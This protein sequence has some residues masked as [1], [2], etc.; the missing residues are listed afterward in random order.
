MLV[1]P[2]IDLRDGKVVRL[3]QGSFENETVYSA[4]P[5]DVMIKWQKEGAK[6]VHVV[7]LDGARE[8]T[9]RNLG[10]LKNILSVAKIPVQF[11]GGLRTYE[12][13]DEVLSAGVSRAVVGTKAFDLGFIGRLAKDFGE[14]VAIG[15]DVREGIIQTHGWQ[16]S[17][18]QCSPDDLCRSLET[19][20]VRTLIF[21]DIARDG[22]M[23]GPNV[24]ALKH[25]LESTKM[26]VILSGG[27]ASLSDL[28]ALSR[29][30]A[31]N[32]VGVIIGKALYEGK[33][34]FQEVVAQLSSPR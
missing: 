7:D 32:F 6:M 1:I 18:K 8:G 19:I 27:I 9:R 3:T 33:I 23:S 4:S 5:P 21:T 15:L 14:R 29:I 11:G 24:K 22:M 34:T 26:S 12:A 2:A 28:K 30:T 16:S 31:K 20:G 13:V 17:E 25:L 10:S